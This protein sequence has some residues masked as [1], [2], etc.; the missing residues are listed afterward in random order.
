MRKFSGYR[1][2]SVRRKL[3]PSISQIRRKRLRKF[4]VGMLILVMSAIVYVICFLG[5]PPIVPDIVRNK[6]AQVHL[7]SPF[8]FSYES[9]FQTEAKRKLASERIP[10]LYKISPTQLGVA[11]KNL[12]T[13]LEFF[14]VN[15]GDFDEVRDNDKDVGQLCERLSAA[16]RKST[17]LAV[18]PED[19]KAVYDYTTA[20]NRRRIFNHAFFHAK[21]ILNDGVYSDGDS[22]FSARSDLYNI[23]IG[24]SREK[25]GRIQ[26]QTD[27]RKMFLTRVRSIGLN[28]KLGYAVYRILNQDLLPNIEFDELKTLEL[29]RSAAAKVKPVVVKVR[30]GE[31]IIDST[32][33]GDS[34]LV[35]EK[36]KAYKKVIL[37]R[38]DTVFSNSNFYLEF[39]A[40]FLLILT[41]ALFIRISKTMRNRQPRTIA[42]FCVLLLIN[43]LVVRLIIYL[44]YAEYFDKNTTFLQI[45][46]YG[47][48]LMLSPIIQVLLFGPYTGF[49]MALLI[50]ALTSM[51]LGGNLFFFILSFT[52]SL[53]AI[54][55]CNGA[56]SRSRVVLAGVIYGLVVSFFSVVLGAS[57]EV[58]LEIMWRQALA[59]LVGGA[60]TSFVAMAL[61]P[62][63][64]RMFNRYSN[65][66]LIDFTDFNNPLL[67]RLQIEAPG[68][69]HHSVMVSYLAEH[70]AVMVGANEM[71]C[72]V[73]AYYHDIGK[74]VKPEF[75]SENQGGGRNPHDDQT[76]SMSAL[77]IKSHIKEGIALAKIEKMPQQIIDAIAQHHG[78][79]II[80]Y[81]YTKAVKLAREAGRE[82]SGDPVE[83]LRQAGIEESTYRHEGRKPQTVENAIIMLADSCEAASR[84]LKKITQH[85][86]EELVGNIIRAKMNDGQLNECPITIKQL[87]RIKS[88][89]VFTMLNMLH[90][91]V[92]YQKTPQK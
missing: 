81:F 46:K 92:E 5:K 47:T 77:I 12:N 26:S 63:I 1:A 19:I 36:L 38:R 78:T 91:R 75:F 15:Q 23:D 21:S 33:A 6:A 89:F 42:A 79:S 84:S 8:D 65:I 56:T 59:A 39:G 3:D 11:E 28:D 53:V 70:A 4:G 83:L 16:L 34:P 71:V 61:L 7:V 74:I 82:I 57:A 50:T 80:S 67:R 20:E 85:G 64:E 52:S 18:S 58:P 54:Y 9:E 37:E 14:A 72:R 44:G 90:S 24:G 68:T 62:I 48:F 22:I 66:T 49:V 29:R 45:F 76:P 73:G 86:V 69:Y 25:A 13:L 2:D 30:E 35:L 40:S 88:S 10:P 32:S 55:F 17:Q 51:M 43:L 87:S 60:L 41:A 27:A 31:T